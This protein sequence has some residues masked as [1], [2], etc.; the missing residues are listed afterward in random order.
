MDLTNANLDTC[1]KCNG[2]SNTVVV[3]NVHWSFVGACKN[4][5]PA[6]DHTLT[7]SNYYS[8]IAQAEQIFHIE[9]FQV[10]DSS[11]CPIT[12]VDVNPV[13]YANLAAV[14]GLT[15]LDKVVCTNRVSNAKCDGASDLYLKLSFTQSYE[16]LR[17][18][19]KMYFNNYDN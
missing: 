11:Y 16:A 17:I 19:M 9:G 15:E 8:S 18:K 12:Q 5:I 10:Y 14:P 4:V 1:L 6:F 3:K 2:P 7:H 13:D